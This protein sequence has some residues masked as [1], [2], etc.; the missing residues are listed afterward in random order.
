[1]LREI[2]RISNLVGEFLLLSKPRHVNLKTV[3]VAK[4]FKDIL[5]IIKN[6]AILHNVDVSIEKKVSALPM[7]VADGELLKQVFLNLCK[8]A[9][10][11]MS[12]G[13]K[14]TIRISKEKTE[15]KLVVEVIDAGPGIPSHTME[16]IFEPFFTTKESGTGLG[17]PICQQIMREIGGLIRVSSDGMGTTFS[18][19]L[20]LA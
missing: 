14:L 6:E 9:I 8:N 16:K 7:V 5:P 13:G 12:D 2:T 1:M 3:S 11:A 4:V 10:E 19:L 17:L 18:V 15:N 20:P